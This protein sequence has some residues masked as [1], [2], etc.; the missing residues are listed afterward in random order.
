[1]SISLAAY[2]GALIRRLLQGCS[3]LPCLLR[4]SV[5]AG[6]QRQARFMCHTIRTL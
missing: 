3:I 2:M 4:A 1:M 6:K 5:E